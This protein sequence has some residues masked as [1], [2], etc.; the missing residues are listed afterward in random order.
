MTKNIQRKQWLA[1]LS[2]VLALGGATQAQQHKEVKFDSTPK[3][4]HV[5]HIDY[6]TIGASFRI[7]DDGN[8]GQ[9]VRFNNVNNRA[10]NTACFIRTGLGE[11]DI[12]YGGYSTTLAPSQNRVGIN[13]RNVAVGNGAI[14]DI[15]ARLPSQRVP[16]GAERV[17][18]AYLYWTASNVGNS[19]ADADNQVQFVVNGHAHN[20]TADRVWAGQYQGRSVESMAGNT[21]GDM[22]AVAN[23][24]HLFTN[25]Q[26]VNTTMTMNDLNIANK[27]IS[28]ASVNVHGT[29]SLYVV[30]EQEG[31][32]NR[33]FNLYDGLEYTYRSDTPTRVEARG[34]NMQTSSKFREDAVSK[35]SIMAADGDRAGGGASGDSL[36]ISSNLAQSTYEVSNA[37][38]PENDVF[39]STVSYENADGTV[40]S[41]V[42]RQNPRNI[43]N[44]LDFDTFDVGDKIKGDAKSRLNQVNVAL[45]SSPQGSEQILL[46]NVAIMASV[47]SSEVQVDKRI[48]ERTVPAATDKPAERTT[49]NV[50]IGQ[51]FYYDI[52]VTSKDRADSSAHEITT[53]DEL[54]AGLEFKRAQFSLDG[55]Q[56][57][58]DDWDVFRYIGQDPVNLKVEPDRSGTT[59]V[60]FPA[61]RRIAENNAVYAGFGRVADR[62]SPPGVNEGVIYRLYS[63][64]KPGTD[65]FQLTNQVSSTPVDGDRKES[66]WTVTVREGKSQIAIEKVVDPTL[67][68]VRDNPAQITTDE[69]DIGLL[70]PGRTG[71]VENGTVTPNE[72]TYTI[73]VRHPGPALP[74]PN[75]VTAKNVVMTDTLPDHL[76]FVS[77][78]FN[79]APVPQGA[80]GQDVVVNVGDLVPAS[81]ARVIIRAKVV[82]LPSRTTQQPFLNTAKA[83]GDN[84]DEVRSNEV[85]TDIE[86]PEIRKSMAK[87]DAKGGKTPHA[88][89]YDETI[90]MT[91][92]PDEQ[93]EYCLHFYNHGTVALNNL[94]VNDVL[95]NDLKYVPNT[96]MLYKD[97]ETR[98]DYESVLTPTDI[99]KLT[100]GAAAGQLNVVGQNVSYVEPVLQP[101][102]NRA[103]CFHAALK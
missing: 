95:Q 56:T 31:L 103:V 80:T 57:F 76:R 100:D 58:R 8:N 5:G 4:R 34:F 90:E 66:S 72:I 10:S 37:A 98:L 29:W 101:N 12:D 15:A 85:R 1:G 83:K 16:D 7:E 77:A 28:C 43:V 73:N 36:T 38:N 45:K 6:I 97:V 44:G 23:V 74:K 71:N 63:T 99:N 25:P 75:T 68:K 54:P 3:Y 51:E 39:N 19:V 86:Y 87:V 64:A 52:K 42:A 13:E 49:E 33:A 61:V 9:P 53:V 78:T 82:D 91:P 59:R 96:G 67:V 21:G 88:L 35:V 93:I 20:I 102:E 65:G 26:D 2:A 41:R 40:E 48:P 55:G 18:A 17:V 81:G 47:G 60:T 94:R 50:P 14:A 24:T 89:A 22:G 27:G 84:T 79:G 46:Y 62:L 92:G 70:I 30:Y 69:S 11:K 32:S